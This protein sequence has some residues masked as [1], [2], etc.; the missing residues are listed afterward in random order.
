MLERKFRGQRTSATVFEMFLSSTTSQGAAFGKA[1]L[2]FFW[3]VLLGEESRRQLVVL[4][5]CFRDTSS[6][7]IKAN[8][9]DPARKDGRNEN[10]YKDIHTSLSDCGTP[11]SAKTLRGLRRCLTYMYVKMHVQDGYWPPKT[12]C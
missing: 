2:C 1:F 12:P 6:R 8:I 11:A 3:M 5:A 7:V 4:T 10:R 9:S